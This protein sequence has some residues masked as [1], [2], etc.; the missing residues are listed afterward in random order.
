MTRGL[1]RSKPILIIRFIEFI[2]NDLLNLYEKLQMRGKHKN[3]QYNQVNIYKG[4]AV[5]VDILQNSFSLLE[6]C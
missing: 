6:N 4:E 3:Y 5:L 2:F 1:Y